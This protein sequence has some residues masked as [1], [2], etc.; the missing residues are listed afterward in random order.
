MVGSLRKI[1][2][3]ASLSNEAISVEM[4]T[5]ILSHIGGEEAA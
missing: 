3:F 5:E 2:A 1:A 4:A